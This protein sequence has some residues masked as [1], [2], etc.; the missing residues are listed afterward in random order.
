[1]LLGAMRNK[2]IINVITG[3]KL[4]YLRNCD[5]QINESDGKIDAILMPKNK[6]VGLFSQEEDY[7]LIKWEQII[8]IGADAILINPVSAGKG[9]A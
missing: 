1:M 5:L 4:G 8:K 7:I 2:V 3:E 6:L 9:N